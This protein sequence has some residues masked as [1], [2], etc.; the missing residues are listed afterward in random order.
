MSDWRGL[1]EGITAHPDGSSTVSRMTLTAAEVGYDGL[2]VRNAAAISDGPS[3]ETIG[4]EYD[5]EVFGGI[6]VET[7]SPDEV[8]GRLPNL[9]REHDVVL[10]T[11]G[12]DRMNRFIA[13]QPAVD[14]LTTP[15]DQDGPDIDPGIA[16]QAKDNDVA[17]EVD[18]GPLSDSGGTRVRYIDRLRRLWRVIDH[19]EVPYV[20]S[21]RASSHR[22][23]VAPRELAAL[24]EIIGIDAEA[25]RGGLSTWLE[26]SE[27]D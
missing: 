24:G 26:L 11:G 15:I 22:G 13:D 18:F 1:G 12:S 27:S 9:A 4:A 3:L 17:I 19:Y 20:I 5:I 2:V 10:V 14:V 7:D 6:E 16:T 23:L 8:S 25:V 21:M